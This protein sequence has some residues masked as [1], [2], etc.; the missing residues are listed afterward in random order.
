M[1]VSGRN[2]VHFKFHALGGKIDMDLRNPCDIST[3]VI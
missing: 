3:G 2:R 1:P